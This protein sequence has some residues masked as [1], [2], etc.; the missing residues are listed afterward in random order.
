MSTVVVIGKEGNQP[1]T[2]TEPTVDYH[3]AELIIEDNG[4]MRLRDTNSAYGTYVM[5]KDGTAERI[6]EMIVSANMIARLGPTFK[7]KIGDLIPPPFNEVDISALKYIQQNYYRRIIIRPDPYPRFQKLQILT[8]I[9]TIVGMFVAAMLVPQIEGSATPWLGKI[10]AVAI[11][12]ILG[13]SFFMFFIRQSKKAYEAR[14]TLDFNYRKNYCCPC[15]HYA[16]G[17]THYENL[18]GTQC[19][20]CH[21]IFVEHQPS[22]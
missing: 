3:H 1:I 13:G 19:P 15:C 2:I 12:L 5:K 17:L 18:L 9:I 21:K 22:T 6:N 8:A 11:V 10:V 16:L 4:Q 20:R 14:E 7:V